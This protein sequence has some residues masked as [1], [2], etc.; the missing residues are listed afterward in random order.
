MSLLLDNPKSSLIPSLHK[1]PF[2][3]KTENSPQPKV[4]AMIHFEF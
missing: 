3:S 2:L 1:N 4:G